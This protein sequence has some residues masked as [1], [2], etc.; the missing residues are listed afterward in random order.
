M[1]SLAKQLS[2]TLLPKRSKSKEESRP[3]HKI[4]GLFIVSKNSTNAHRQ[5]RSSLPVSVVCTRFQF[6][7]A[8]G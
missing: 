4:W 8:Y 3:T 2:G 6:P 5:G 7:D 1:L